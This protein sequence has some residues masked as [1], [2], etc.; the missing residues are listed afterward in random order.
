MRGD[1]GVLGPRSARQPPGPC[2]EHVHG[3]PT[4]TAEREATTWTRDGSRL[5]GTTVGTDHVYDIARFVDQ[6]RALDATPYIAQKSTY[7]T[8]DASTTFQRSDEPCQQ[9]RKLVEQV[10]RWLRTMGELWE[11][12]R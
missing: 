7:S 9:E 6:V 10:F 1:L 5:P 12:P 2:G 8:I 4:E 3:A 11:A